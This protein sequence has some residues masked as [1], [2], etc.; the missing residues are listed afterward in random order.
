MSGLIDGVAVGE[1]NVNPK[2]SADFSIMQGGGPAVLRAQQAADGLHHAGQRVP[3]LRQPRAGECDRAA[4]SG[5]RARSAAPTSTPRACSPRPRSP[6]RRTR[7]RRSSTPT[8]SCRSRTWC[9]PATGSPTSSQ[10][11]SVTYANTYGRF[12]VLDNLCSY[13]FAAN[14]GVP[15][16]PPV[17]ARGRRRRRRS[18]APATAFR[19]PPASPSSTT[20]R[21]AGPKEDRGSTPRSEPR[22]RAVPALARDGQ[23]RGDGR[24]AHR[25]AAEPGAPHRRRRR[26]HSRHRQAAPRSGRVRDRPQRRHPA[27]ELHLAR[28]F[29]AQQRGRRLDQLAALLRGDERA[30]PRQLQPVPRL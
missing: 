12:S 26:G 3:G 13:S 9:S 5:G 30:A 15:G 10:S 2:F 11:I 16:G 17:R 22:R 1:P 25:H 20:R 7:R 28:L 29:R 21:R 14:G 8:A 6:T 23:G 4:Q 24:G 19:R 27:A 18:S